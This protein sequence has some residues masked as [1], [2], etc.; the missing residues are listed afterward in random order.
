MNKLAIICFASFATFSMAGVV[1]AKGAICERV[2]ADMFSVDGMTDDWETL[3]GIRF[4]SGSDAQLDVRCAYDEEKLYIAVQAGDDRVVRGKKEDK[5]T[6]S[7][8]SGTGR[9]LSFTVLPGTKRSPR[10]AIGLPRFVELEDSLQR[11]G[12]SVE[13]AVPLRKLPGWS[14]TL[15]YLRASILFHDSDGPGKSRRVGMKRGKLHFSDAASTYKQFMQTTGLKNR[16]VRLDKLVD[17]D[18]G[19][20]A[21]RVIIGGTVMGVLGTSFSYMGLPIASPRD[22]LSARVVRFDGSGRHAVLTE[23][24]QHGNGG[25]RDVVIIWFAN[26]N[27]GFDAALTVETRKQRGDAFI[28][29][30]WS[31]VPRGKHRDGKKK[32][33]MRGVDLLVQVGEVV[34]FTESSFREAPASDAKSILAPWGEQQ[35]ALYYLEG[36]VAYGGDAAANLPK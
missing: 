21:E 8:R 27:G 20:G 1:H 13:L 3:K 7:L 34:G 12:F 36:S 2:Q 33:R 17:I 11:R 4:G 6:F 16:D 15:P 22:L 10:K 18:P 5:I 25:S 14:A 9:A 23:L 28:V 19:A 29:N 30:T 32:R 24:R 31:L 26:G 35:S